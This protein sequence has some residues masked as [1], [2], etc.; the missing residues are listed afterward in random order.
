MSPTK[1]VDMFAREVTMHLKADS[2]TKFTQKLEK[3]IIPLLRLQQGF[4]DEIA[5]VVS[6]GRKA[7]AISLW[8]NKENAETY[9]SAKYPE[10]LKDMAEVIEGT[11]QV[12][13]YDVSNSTWYKIAAPIA[14]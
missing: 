9:N 11:P 8:D 3:E 4:K 1:E 7:V 13:T 10:V 14:A 6:G 12:E 5:L 2:Q